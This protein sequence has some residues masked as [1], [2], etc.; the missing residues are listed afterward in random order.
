MLSNTFFKTLL[1]ALTLALF[2]S[3]S[4]DKSVNNDDNNNNNNTQAL[5]ANNTMLVDGDVHIMDKI[6]LFHQFALDE[7][8]IFVY[9]DKFDDVITVKLS[10]KIPDASGT[11]K[12]E[13]RKSV[14]GH[15]SN[16]FSID[17]KASDG[18]N[19]NS[20]LD[21]SSITG[22]KTTGNLYVKQNANGTRTIYFNNITMGDKHSSPTMTKKFSATFTFSNDLVPEQSSNP[23][24]HDLA[25]DK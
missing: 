8:W 7:I 22:V 10:K 16:E 4:D 9:G 20:W 6:A 12:L 13:Y 18:T 23:T 21:E 17:I 2:I 14:L 11:T 24:I 19:V 5:A 15:E 3:C 1:L 25:N